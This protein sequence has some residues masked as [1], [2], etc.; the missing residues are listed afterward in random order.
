MSLVDDLFQTKLNLS[1][2]QISDLP[3]LHLGWQKSL[4]LLDLSRN[5][6]VTIPPTVCRLSALLELHINNNQ[7]DELPKKVKWVTPKLK[8]LN[9]SQNRLA[10]SHISRK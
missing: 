7:V 6:F 4:C 1:G 10:C 9:L 5:N 2:N 3:D 8:V